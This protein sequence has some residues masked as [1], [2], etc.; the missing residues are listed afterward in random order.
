MPTIVETYKPKIWHLLIGVNQYT[1][2]CPPNN[3]K[4]PAYGCRDIAKVLNKI[5]INH[6]EKTGKVKN[7]DK[8]PELRQSVFH[9]VPYPSDKTVKE[10]IKKT[11]E[12][13][14]EKI[15]NLAG[16]KDTIVFYFAGHGDRRGFLYLTDTSTQDPKT[17]LELDYLVTKLS[18]S[19]AKEIILFIDACHSGTLKSYIKNQEQ[20]TQSFFALLSSSANQSSYEFP[21]LKNTLFTHYLLQALR[22][23][24]ADK[25]GKINGAVIVK[26]IETQIRKYIELDNS[27]LNFNFNYNN[28]NNIGQQRKE[29]TREQTVEI[30]INSTSI[31][32]LGQ[33]TDNE[34]SDPLCRILVMDGLN[35]PATW[36]EPLQKRGYVVDIWKAECK[37]VEK[38]RNFYRGEGKVLLYLRGYLKEDE[39]LLGEKQKLTIQELQETLKQ[40]DRLQQIILLDCLG[41]SQQKVKSWIEKLQ[42]SEDVYVVIGVATPQKNWFINRLEETLAGVEE[43]QGLTAITWLEKLQEG[44]LEYFYYTIIKEQGVIEIWRPLE[45]SEQPLEEVSLYWLYCRQRVLDSLSKRPLYFGKGKNFDLYVDLALIERKKKPERQL[46]DNQPYAPTEEE[47][48]ENRRFQGEEFFKEV[49]RDDNPRKKLALIGEPGAGKTTYGL[50]IADYILYNTNDL[51]IWVSL[52]ELREHSLK[53]FLSEVWLEKALNTWKLTQE[54]KDTFSKQFKNRRIWLLLDG[55]DEITGVKGSVLRHIVEQLDKGG[56]IDV[57]VLLTCRTNLWDANQDEL[58]TREFHVY[59]TLEFRP[60]QI[61]KFIENYFKEKPQVGDNLQKAL[62]QTEKQQIRELVKNPLRLH[63]LCDTCSKCSPKGGLPSTKTEL[64]ESFVN[65]KHE[66]NHFTFGTPKKLPELE[67]VLGKLA[68]W[69]IDDSSS[70]VYLSNSKIP[71]D[72]DLNL[73]IRLGWLNNVG[74][75]AGTAH[76]ILYAFEHQ[77]FQEYFAACAVTDWDYFL[78]R[79]H[80]DRPVE[81]KQYRIF[82][83][84]WK[85]VILLWFGR[86]DVEKKEKETFIQALVEFK[87]GCGKWNFQELDRGFYEYQAYWLATMAI[88]EFKD[89]SK[90]DEIVE[91]IVKYSFGYFEQNRKKWITFPAPLTNA[92]IRV[93]LAGTDRKIIK[94]LSDLCRPETQDNDI[95]RLAAMSLAEIDPDNHT[96]LNT[97][98]HLCRNLYR[99]PENEPIIRL[100]TISLG[101]IGLGNDEVLNTLIFLCKLDQNKN[102]SKLPIKSSGEIELV[103]PQAIAALIQLCFIAQK[104]YNNIYYK[105]SHLKNNEDVVEIELV[106][107]QAIAALIQLSLT[108]HNE[109][110]R[111]QKADNSLKEIESDILEHIAALI[112]LC[113]TVQNEYIRWQDAMR[114]GKIGPS[115]PKAVLALIEL[116]RNVLNQYISWQD[117]KRL[118]K[119]SSE[120]DAVKALSELCENNDQDIQRLTAIALAKIKPGNNVTVAKN[121]LINL[122]TQSESEV[123]KSNVPENL[124]LIAIGLEEIDPGNSKA[125]DIL[126][127]LLE[128][129]D[130]NKYIRGLAAMSLGEMG[131]NNLIA[132]NALSKLCLNDQNDHIRWVATNSLGKIG[133]DNS[134]AID[135]LSKLCLKDPTVHIR[136]VAANSLRKIAPSNPTATETLIDL[137]QNKLDETNFVNFRGFDVVAL[138]SL[139]ESIDRAFIQFLVICQPNEDLISGGIAE[140][141]MHIPDKSILKIF[142]TIKKELSNKT[143]ENNSKRYDTC[144]GIIH[145]Y[146]QILSYPEFHEF[147]IGNE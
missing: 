73:A 85:E 7:T 114:L 48:K 68:I 54:M 65:Y 87:D 120:P 33:K 112:Q 26:Y 95:R 81:D 15:C 121:T 97:L 82:E 145:N 46:E 40:G 16:T 106:T 139:P 32:I 75:A 111:R 27:Q 47:A 131:K 66:Y 77:T 63:L 124:W 86:K 14:L 83:A 61:K 10:P 108:A 117:Q 100:A 129:K 53:E 78:P 76:D 59:R 52:A 136:W 18:Q 89:C 70:K 56:L 92:A 39:L 125:I 4:Y 72:L 91:G 28:T 45:T 137:V 12:E 24:A 9:D 60:E 107:P 144:Y 3:L 36:Y 133:K 115:N 84:K 79:D 90:A 29:I 69:A 57:N 13:E 1:N 58:Y 130:E 51:P 96:V 55:V 141:L 30:V 113:L 34:N 132:I 93:I 103:T 134:T 8:N 37:P 20:K 142:T 49:I 99:N 21:T 88:A 62:E 35:K 25:D 135:A 138:D 140:S 64:Y 23:G 2:S 128:V 17:G 94:A 109:S 110:I 43:T 102:I 146:A 71:R 147:W 98:I 31:P 80:V 41:T 116:C 101:K 123:K 5:L 44:A 122:L 143:R 104:K 67:E 118:G 19:K 127:K 11:V 42:I 22:G 50:K 126:I 74:I 38:L 119:E 6:L 105:D